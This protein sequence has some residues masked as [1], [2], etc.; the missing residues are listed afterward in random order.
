MYFRKWR[1]SHQLHHCKTVFSVGEKLTAF[2]LL[3]NERTEK[4]KSVYSYLYY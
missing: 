1:K 2:V 3:V 4:I